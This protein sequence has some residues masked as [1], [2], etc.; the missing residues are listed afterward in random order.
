[1]KDGAVPLNLVI[2]NLMLDD[3]RSAYSSSDKDTGTCDLRVSTL[4]CF[5]VICEFGH[6]ACSAFFIY[7]TR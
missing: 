7:E 3:K 4:S 5:L 2:M 6:V 1:M